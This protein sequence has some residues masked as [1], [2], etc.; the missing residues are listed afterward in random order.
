MSLAVAWLNTRCNL[1]RYSYAG[2]QRIA[3]AECNIR[4]QADQS[5][6]EKL[7][8]DFH[9]IMGKVFLVVASEKSSVV[10]ENE[11]PGQQEG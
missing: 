3:E 2:H 10:L 11:T 1:V 4:G 8:V 7:P 6:T 5:I 9:V